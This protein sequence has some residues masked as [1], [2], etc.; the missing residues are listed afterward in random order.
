MFAV[1]KNMPLCLSQGLSLCRHYIRRNIRN[2]RASGERHCDAHFGI[3]QAQD[4]RHPCFASRAQ[5]IGPC[6]AKQDALCAQGQHSND[7]QSR[8]YAAIGQYR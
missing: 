5:R 1:L 8:P 2:G 7:I 4:V 3:D 6:A